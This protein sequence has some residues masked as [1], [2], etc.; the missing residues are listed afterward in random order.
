MASLIYEAAGE[1]ETVFFDAVPS[2][3]HGAS[4]TPTD[5]P[6][7]VGAPLTDHVRQNRDSLSLEAMVTNA[8]IMSPN[9]DGA[10]GSPRPLTLSVGDSRLVRPALFPIGAEFLAETKQFTPQTLQF[11]QAFDR[12][13]AVWAKL[14]KIKEE[15]LEVTVVTGLQT[16]DSM[17]LSSI[18][19]PRQGPAGS[20]NFG[21]E[22]VAFRYA[23][24]QTVGAPDPVQP[25]GRP[26]VAQGAQ[27]T[28]PPATQEQAAAVQ[29]T[30]SGL[31][32][33]ARNALPGG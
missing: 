27:P 16:Y 20:I 5:H 25:R 12:V 26:R 31:L 28:E 24:T 22:F 3:K 18:S 14:R 21:L 13:A 30:Y 8:P 4:S 33:M 11:D 17:L 10:N 15:A 2:E 29:S 6:V 7:E 32:D 23:T 1:L 9:V 19:A